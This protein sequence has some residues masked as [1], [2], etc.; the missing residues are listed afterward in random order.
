MQY[1]GRY[2][3]DM[4]LVHSN[5]QTLL[6]AI[7]PI[8]Q[9]LQDQLHLTLHPRKIKLQPAVHGFPFLG[10]YIFPYRTYPGRRIVSNFRDCLRHPLLDQGKQAQR[11]QSYVGLLGHCDSWRLV[12]ESSAEGTFVRARCVPSAPEQN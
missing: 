10:V 1:Y 8:R 6:D 7:E 4:L 5:K 2:V 9:F 12:R 11:V 3:D